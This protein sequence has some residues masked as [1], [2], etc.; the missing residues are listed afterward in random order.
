MNNNVIPLRLKAQSLS[1]FSQ[2]LT[3]ANEPLALHIPSD[4]ARSIRFTAG[5]HGKAPME[6]LLD[7]LKSGFP[8]N[9]A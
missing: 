5:M 9:A 7:W 3:Q 6:F 4:L 8:E 2:A 1:H